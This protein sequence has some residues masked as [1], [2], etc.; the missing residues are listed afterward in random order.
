[1]RT[2]WS[3]Q[4]GSS[5]YPRQPASR[6]QRLLRC[7]AHATRHLPRHPDLLA[8]L[9]EGELAG[10]VIGCWFAPQPCHGH[11]LATLTADPHLTPAQAL[12]LALAIESGP[13][14]HPRD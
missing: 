10:R 4:Q 2:P 8:R 14:P 11:V 12:A 13:R 9:A 3:C 7:P 5:H 1:M 6:T